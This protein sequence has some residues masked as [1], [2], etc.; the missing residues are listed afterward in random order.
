MVNPKAC[1]RRLPAAGFVAAL[2]LGLLGAAPAGAQTRLVGNTSG[3][4]SPASVGSIGSVVTYVQAQAFTTGDSVA[5]YTLG[6]VSLDGRSNYPR[7]T[8]RVSLHAPD[9][10]GR[11]GA[12]QALLSGSSGVTAG[13]TNPFTAPANTTLSAATTYFVVVR[14]TGPLAVLHSTVSHDED[15]DS[16]LGWSI[17]DLRYELTD[18]TEWTDDDARDRPLR[19]VVS[20]TVVEATRPDPPTDLTAATSTM[21]TIALSWTAPE[22][23]GS[24]A[25]VGYR[26]EWSASGVAPWMVAVDDTGT[27]AASW[28]HEGLDPGATYHYR[29][30]AI[31][32]DRSVSQPSATA[33][34]ATVVAATPPSPATGPKLAGNTSGQLFNASVGYAGEVVTYVQAQAFTTGDGVAGYTLGSVSLGAGYNY[35]RTTLRVSLHAADGSGR[36]GAEQVL[37]SGPSGVTVGLA[38]TFTAPADTTL[39]ADT[40]YF[41]VVRATGPAASLLTTVSHD[42]DLDSALGWSIADLRYQLSDTTE[43][44]D[45]DTL[46]R[47]LRIVVS[48]T[49]VGGTRPGRPTD[50]TGGTSTGTTIPLSWTAPQDPGSSDILGY[51]IEWSVD[52]NDPWMVAVDDTGS[53]A[54]TWTHRGLEPETT[55]HYRVRAINGEMKSEPSVRNA[56]ATV[57]AAVATG[58]PTGLTVG[59]STGTTVALSWTAPEDP[60]PRAIAGYRVEWSASGVA[61]WMVAVN[62]TGTTATSWTH[63]DLEPGVTYYYRVRAINGD[64]VASPPSAT[65]RAATV[66]AATPTPGTGPKLVGNTLG[67]TFRAEIGYLNSQITYVQAQAFTTGG[68]VEGYTL[69]SVSLDASRDYP[70]TT[71]RVSLHA[72]DGSG[73]PG[74]EQVPLSGPS[75]VTAGLTNTFTA[76]AGTT[77]SADTTYFVVVRATG[78]SALLHLTASR[79]EDVDSALGWSIADLR[80]DLSDATDWTH[81]RVDPSSKPLR[82]VVSGTVVGATRPGRPTDL[83]AATSTLRTIPLSWT[84]PQDPGS[85][86]IL[87]YRIEWSGDGNDPWMVAVDDTGSTATAWTHEGLEPETTY[88]YRVRAINAETRSEPSVRNAAATA[89][90]VAPGPPAGLT[91]A[92]STGT[93]IP[94][95]W[96]AP[97]DSGSSAIVGYRIEWSG[98]GN[99][100]W[101][102]AVDDTGSTATTWTQEGL[103]PGTT[104]H[105][106]VRAI[107]GELAGGPSD[108]VSATSRHAPPGPPTELGAGAPHATMIPLSWTAP[109]DP[110]SSDVTGYRIEWSADGNEPWTVAAGDT[111]APETSY[112]HTQLTPETTYHYRVSAIN[113]EGV[114]AT[115]AAV[116]ATTVAPAPPGPPT[117]VTAAAVTGTSVTLTWMEPENP[118]SGDLAGYRVE[119]SND[120]GVTWTVAIDDTGSPDPS[121]THRERT[122]RTAYDYRVSAINSDEAV[123]EPSATTRVETA[124][125]ADNVLVSNASQSI[126]FLSVVASFSSRT[127]VLQSFTTGGHPAGYS[128]ASVVVQARADAPGASLAAALYLVVS[129]DER[130]RLTGFHGL[131]DLSAGDQS[132]RP[133]ENIVLRPDTTYIL[134]FDEV[135]DSG[136][137]ELATTSSTAED[138]GSAPG[139]SLGDAY[140]WIGRFI[141][142]VV[143]NPLKV[144]VNGV[145]VPFTYPGKPTGLAAGEATLTSIPLSWIA[146][147]DFGS[148]PIV[149][150]RVEY[151]ANGG[152]TWW[153]ATRD[154]GSRDPAWT[155]EGLEPE[156]TLKYRVRAVNS[157]VAGP[158]SDPIDAATPATLPPG[159]PTGLAVGTPSATAAPLSWTAPEDP[160]SSEI[161]GYRVEW[162][163]DG[164]E[165]WMVAVDDTGSTAT[166]WTHEGLAP[167]TA[168]HYRVRAISDAGAS[169]PSDAVGATTA[170]ASDP[171]ALGG[172]STAKLVGNF[173]RA[174]SNS[175]P[176]GPSGSGLSAR[177]DARAQSFTTG[178]GEG[179]GFVLSSVV[180][181]VKGMEPG[182]T[183][184]AFLHTPSSDRPGTEVAE[185]AA[186]ATAA[187][188]HNEFMAS[189][190]TVLDGGATYFVVFRG[191][192]GL[193]TLNVT[194]S[195]GEDAD[196]EAGWTIGDDRYSQY[197]Q[198]GNWSSV[199]SDRHALKITV[200]GVVVPRTRPGRPAGLAAG[201][202]TET[203]VPLSWS[204]PATDGGAA[205]TGYRVEHSTDGGRIWTLAEVTGTPGT[206]WTHEGLLPGTTY[207]YR[208]IA[209]NEKGVSDPS[210]AIAAT[211]AEA[212][213]WV[214]SVALASDPGEDRTYAI[215]DT[216]RATVAF[217]EAVDVDASGGRPRLAL[218]VGGRPRPAHVT[219]AT[220]TAELVFSWVVAEDDTDADGIAIGA[221]ALA[222]DGGTITRAGDGSVAAVLTHLA[223]GA[224][225][226]HLVD[227]VRPAVSGASVKGSVVT[228]TWSEALNERSAPP[229]SAFTVSLGAETA[230]PVLAVSVHGETVT[231]FLAGPVGMTDTVGIDY[232]PPAGD[233]AT[234]LEDPAGNDADAFSLAA[235][236]VA[237]ETLAS[238]DAQLDAL[239]VIGPDSGDAVLSPP[240]LGEET[241]YTAKVVSSAT[242]VTVRATAAHP[243]ATVEY[244]DADGNALADA[245][246]EA[247]GLQVTLGEGV[248]T[249]EVKVTAE[250]GAT[251]RTYTVDIA[252]NQGPSI[253]LVSPAPG[254]EGA[255]PANG[256]AVAVD[257]N[258]FTVATLGGHDADGDRLTW[259]RSG[260]DAARF[261]LAS[262]TADGTALVGFGR[263]LPDY[264]NP[265][266][267]D[268]DNEYRVTLEV[269]DGTESATVELAV[270]VGDVDEPPAAPEAPR[271]SAAAG[272]TTSL[273]VRWTAPGNTGPAITS[274]DVQVREGASGTWLD[275]PQDVAETSTT[276]TALTTRTGYQVRVRATNDEGDGGWSEAGSG[277]TATPTAPQGLVA[278]PGNGESTLSWSAPAS[279]GGEP[280]LHYEVRWKPDGGTFGEDWT[281]AG[282]ATSHTVGSL[283]N[284]TRYTFEVRAVTV[285]GGGAAQR[286]TATPTLRPEPIEVEVRGSVATVAFN[287]EVTWRVDTREGAENISPQRYFS[288]HTGTVAP[289]WSY[290]VPPT[291]PGQPAAQPAETFTHDGDTV[292]LTFAEAVIPGAAAWLAYDGSSV[293]APLGDAGD[294]A[295]ARRVARF[296][297]EVRTPAA[298]AGEP[299][300]RVADSRADEGDGSMS[301]AVTLDAAAAGTVTVDYETADRTATAGADYTAVGGTLT[302]APGDI[303]QPVSVPILD[304]AVDDTGETFVL[305]LRNVSGAVL[306][307]SKATGTIDNSDPIPKAWLARFGRAVAGHVTDAI[308]ERLTGR[309]GG[310]GT[311]L[312]LAGH[313]VSL[314]GG[315][316]RGAPEAGPDP[317]PDPAVGLAAVAEAFAGGAPGAAPAGR[318]TGRGTGRAGDGWTRDGSGTRTLTKRDL[319]LG[320]SFELALTKDGAG[321][322]SQGTGARWTAWGGAAASRFDGRADGLTLD[323][324]VTTFLVGAD[325]ARERWTAGVA[326]ALSEG[327]GGYRDHAPDA[328]AGADGHRSGV[329]GKLESTLTSVHPYAS[330]TVSERLTGWG[331]LGY[332]TGDLTLDEPGVGRRTTDTTMEMAAVGAQGV[333]VPAAQPGGFTS[334]VRTDA[335]LTRMRSEAVANAGAPGHL[336]AA[337]AQT[338]RVRLL[339]DG[340]R[341]FAVGE[342]RALTPSL[343][344]GFRHDGG[345]AETGLGLEVGGRLRYHDP[346][347]RL[348]AE[349]GA[350][351]LVAHRDADYAEWGASASVGIVPDGSGRGLSLRIAPSLGA[352]GGGGAERLWSHDDARGLAAGAGRFEPASRLEAEIGHGFAVFGGRGTATP[353]A[354]LSRSGG[355]QTRRLGQRLELGPSRWTLEGASG[356]N[357]RTWTAG[358]GYRVGGDLDL[359]VD[360]TRREEADG[361]AAVHG[362]TLRARLRW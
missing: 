17:A 51:R 263:P 183:L 177:Q 92:T 187:T 136:T 27:T 205:I 361:G 233:G 350:R 63:E 254:E 73:R 146:P 210:E 59:T 182:A 101:T 296:I 86:D 199:I 305:L 91:A 244:L 99:A 13:L 322:G 271:V 243:R 16:A 325:A 10:S 351:S 125:P 203:T 306:D 188:G 105:Y 98:D 126:G 39:S 43:W 262:N 287:R 347:R 224:D 66:A 190:N 335:V 321:G 334:S 175:T 197:S 289:Q 275:G 147:E 218:D 128:L 71:L 266:D 20:G 297:E 174:G 166:A 50:L 340:S 14:A 159:P 60:G 274:Y 249:L 235:A 332:G 80:Y 158:P 313:R 283:V 219:N 265:T 200:N 316:G 358:Y 134:V 127:R 32:G 52:G 57:P 338:S 69:G 67:E 353:H 342:G 41:V 180:V 160:G 213:L 110:G 83:A 36:P 70:D 239:R 49:V 74:A 247:D 145:P 30:R 333:L 268:E 94:L 81:V 357:G 55:Y 25:I 206:S 141:S 179:R 290:G 339:L 278:S 142:F 326:V 76:P 78:P 301:F 163:A 269:S 119:W 12:E 310:G 31:N 22:D 337:K 191:K 95:S 280:L 2:A 133:R 302:F 111:G 246:A 341:T 44:A 64:G 181:D 8:L 137:L 270:T 355:S 168:Y 311:H 284:A 72:P 258:A 228:L 104:R 178:S 253:T 34:A 261:L 113:G 5:G 277:T 28:T 303:E 116:S 315:G 346:G 19:I 56:A 87:G 96:T 259:T 131:Y 6:S 117:Q 248:T 140:Q 294:D 164:S 122:P 153:V 295:G 223:V 344:V 167:A 273:D 285:V 165:P 362:L 319:L 184:S 185:L 240:F 85:S 35:P 198:G 109:E 129:E 231:L 255:D 317:G 106:R 281:G 196:S 359:G 40:T 18:T 318:G 48:G 192:G 227:G 300:M 54:T 208:V 112:R 312:T 170:A 238:A 232:A 236:D 292:S 82:I 348:T 138:P 186:P 304:D 221:N 21:T 107:N 102:V 216:V 45:G 84:A 162:S 209:V 11:P 3:E 155:H 148:S 156:T 202:A 130:T 62:D 252:R 204:A 360:A 93:T 15:V 68:G 276:V 53:T 157:E 256:F 308:S 120:A 100:P 194:D 298:A 189:A 328:D 97:Q 201:T 220:S 61:P 293:H 124:R 217:S 257:E 42:E 307:D 58:P 324:E 1:W 237:N 38:N 33:R 176:V 299:R 47:P 245:D 152:E 169:L 89:P 171:A 234:P 226:G 354:G 286:V 222:L 123:G 260:D 24:N 288:L 79:D 309:S 272:S 214:T 215:G 193:T 356:A 345:D 212:D 172:A 291:A 343:E 225:A 65:A 327:E 37:L 150:Y 331:I 103:T 250:D 9:S 207:G 320:S 241:G 26:I 118:G 211:T 230:V 88:H 4:S 46:D 144:T 229:G 336:A 23:P 195:D 251:T 349:A 135:A 267:A 329:S 90:P 121:Y 77:L 154:T 279:T 323:G 352:A 29:V 330:V 149:G 139:W 264:E 143:P 114:S 282:T 161:A 7:T 314:A 242:S 151:S 115:S 173:S 108:P 132:L 75:S